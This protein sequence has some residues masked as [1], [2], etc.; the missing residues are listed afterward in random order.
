MEDTEHPG[1]V[2]EPDHAGRALDRLLGQFCESPRLQALVASIACG[3]QNMEDTAF[4]VV[5][6]AQNIPTATLDAL[7][8]W[9]EVVGIQRGAL[10]KA[11]FARYILLTGR[12][13]TAGRLG[14]GERRNL[15][16]LTALWVEAFEPATVSVSIVGGVVG[17]TVVFPG[18]FDQ[19][20]ARRGAQLVSDC[21][22]MGAAVTVAAGSS[23]VFRF[24]SGP[25]FDNGRL[26]DFTFDGRHRG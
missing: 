22:P 13:L 18:D 2:Y 21:R 12:C 20:V 26:A 9:G 3:V 7:A 11:Q 8:K 14:D 23:N 5:V 10:T 16:D 15:E 17:I 19:V 24:D 1:L 4:S 6:G 25:G